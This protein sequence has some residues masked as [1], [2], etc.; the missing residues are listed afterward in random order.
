MQEPFSIAESAEE[1]ETAGGGGFDAEIVAAHRTAAPP[2]GFD[3]LRPPTARDLVLAAVKL[4]PQR[5]PG[6]AIAVTAVASGRGNNRNGRGGNSD[7][8]LKL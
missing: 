1:P 4:K 7:G 2:A 6:G 3:P 8:Q 5:R